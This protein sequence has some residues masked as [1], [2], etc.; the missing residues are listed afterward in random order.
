MTGWRVR[1]A[2][3]PFECLRSEPDPVAWVEARAG[4]VHRDLPTRRTFEFGH[5]GARWFAKIHRG[6]GEREL[7]K[8][9]LVLRLPVFGAEAELQAIARLDAAGLPTLSV[10]AW[11]VS[12]DLLP[13]R[14]RSF[15]VT[16]AVE[17]EETLEDRA[18]APLLEP[19]ERRDRIR[20]LAGLVRRMHDAGVNHRDLYLVHVLLCSYGLRLIDLHR[21]QVRGA[22]PRRWR[23]KDLAALAF[24]ARATGALGPADERRFVACYARGAL[25]RDEDFWRDVERRAARMAQRGAQG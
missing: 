1:A 5:A 6:V 12:R 19:G 16:R 18:L 24:S 9:L 25:R 23:A 4:R 10:A 15:L 21:A 7:L 8:N 20:A 13:T 17:H 3:A 2:E 14:R 22:V 11:G